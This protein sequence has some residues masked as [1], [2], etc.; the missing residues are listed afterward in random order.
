MSGAALGVEARKG[1]AEHE[2]PEAGETRGGEDGDIEETDT[3]SSALDDEGEEALASVEFMLEG[4][5]E[6]GVVSTLLGGEELEAGGAP[7]SGI[8]QWLH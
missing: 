1:P 3:D 5:V 7:G 2:R 4:E 8:A 6:V